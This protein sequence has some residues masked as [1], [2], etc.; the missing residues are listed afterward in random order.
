[1][2]VL[3]SDTASILMRTTWDCCSRTY[4][5]SSTPALDQWLMRV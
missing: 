2:R 1:M 5:R 4:T 3:C